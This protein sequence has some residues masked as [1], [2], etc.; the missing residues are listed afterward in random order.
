MST[1]EVS[2]KEFEEMQAVAEEVEQRSKRNFTNITKL[3]CDYTVYKREREVLKMHVIDKC[4]NCN[5]KFKE[6]D[7]LYS[8]YVENKDTKQNY[9][10][11]KKCARKQL[12]F[13]SN[14]I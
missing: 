2:E 5:R 11:C 7:F 9:I 6:G 10:I 13:I 12:D 8:A 1:E 3:K 14:L 4:Q